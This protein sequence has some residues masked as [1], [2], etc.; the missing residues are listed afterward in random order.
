MLN[1]KRVLGLSALGLTLVAGSILADGHDEKKGYGFKIGAELRT[2]FTYSDNGLQEAVVNDPDNSKTWSLQ[3]A[4][5][6]MHGNVGANTDYRALLRFEDVVN[7]IGMNLQD[8]VELGHV[9][10]HFSD[11]VSVRVGKG[12]RLLCN[13]QLAMGYRRCWVARS[14]PDWFGA[15]AKR[16]RRT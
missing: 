11:M 5:I 16:C 3:A 9:T 2:E 13:L 6:K 8:A 15:Y 1:S 7:G 10:H 14:K 12:A 4:K